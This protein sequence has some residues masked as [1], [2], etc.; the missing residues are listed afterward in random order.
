[1][2]KKFLK[3]KIFIR[4]CDG[5]PIFIQEYKSILPYGKYT[6][7]EDNILI[8]NNFAITSKDRT[9]FTNKFVNI[10]SKIIIYLLYD[11]LYGC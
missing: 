4:N 10:I 11:E 9:W 8:N 6:N 7:I 2:G 5:K 1:M 3:I